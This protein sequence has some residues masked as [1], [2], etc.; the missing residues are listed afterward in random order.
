MIGSSIFFLLAAGAGFSLLLF[1]NLASATTRTLAQTVKHATRRQVTI[2]VTEQEAVIAQ[3][4]RYMTALL[5]GQYDTM[6]SMLHPAMQAMWPDETAF[7]H[8]WQMRFQG[9]TLQK[10]ILGKVTPLSSWV[11]PETM[12]RYTEVAMMPVSLTLTPQLAPDGLAPSPGAAQHANQLLQNLPFIVQPAG[13]GAGSQ[14]HVLNGGPVDLEAPILPPTLPTSKKLNVP[15]LMYHHITAVPPRNILDRSLTVTPTVFG[16][17]LDH[18]K[19]QGYHTITF[20]QLFD[21]LYYDAPLPTRPII[22]TFDDG[23]SDAYTFAYPILKAHGYSGMF[24]IIT[25]KVGWQGQATWDQLREMLANGMGM[26][27]H[28]VHH[29]DMG[30]VW[31]NSPQQ[32]QQELEVSQRDMQSHLGIA[33]QQFCYPSGEPFR[34]GTLAVQQG[35]MDLLRKNGYVGATT[36][37]PP[38]GMT[39]DSQR[40]FVLVRARIDG[41]SS[42]AEFV[43]RF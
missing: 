10:F 1:P 21:T 11:D 20:N 33:I 39:Q 22:L 26:G 34:H 42:L 31:Q 17:Q 30:R 35:V 5:Q 27:S 15:I 36:D 29:V 6:W 23:Y 28:T 12:K 32:A 41:R 13:R 24:Y 37:P 14:W 38:A 4:Q 16:Q 8:Y 18:L 25:G 3:G 19:M 2:P 9:F 40:P 43:N 7:A